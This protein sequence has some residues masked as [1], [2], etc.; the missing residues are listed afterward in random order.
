MIGHSS[1]VRV[2]VWNKFPRF[3]C[4][5]VFTAPS[6]TVFGKLDQ[7]AYSVLKVADP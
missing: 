6:K 3:R 4:Q 2:F 5:K 7:M 1:K